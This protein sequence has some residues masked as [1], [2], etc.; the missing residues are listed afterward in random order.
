LI[1]LTLAKA[2]EIGLK[3]QPSLKTME[4]QRNVMAY[5]VDISRTRFFPSFSANSFLTKANSPTIF[6]SVSPSTPSY[7]LMVPGESFWN[8]NVSIM[9]PLFTGGRNVGILKKS[10]LEKE[11]TDYDYQAARL[12]LILQIKTTYRMALYFRELRQTYEELV[13]ESETRAKI[14]RISY[15]AGKVAYINVLRNETRL[16]Q[17]RQTLTN[18]EKDYQ[19]TLAQLR[20]RMGVAPNSVI[21]LAKEPLAPEKV[22]LTREQALDR[23]FK[24]RPDILALSRRL[25]AANAD[26]AVSRSDL[27]PQVAFSATQDFFKGENDSID[28][29]YSVGLLVSFP[30]FRSGETFYKI[31][32]SKENLKQ[33]EYNYQSKILETQAEVDSAWFALHAAAENIETARTGVKQAAEDF[34]I[35]K[36]AYEA[37]KRIQVEYLD[38]QVALFQARTDYAKAI[39]DYNI[40]V[41]QLNRI[42]GKE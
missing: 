24:N 41:D 39:L 8:Q 37:G 7:S 33:A 27:Y 16:A 17:S 14:D 2:I 9:V 5:E 23:A 6:D 13:K 34:R 40:S 15:E 30:F 28:S 25:N 31:G 18:T 35:I 1:S 42:I 12:D 38:A 10:K 11:A 20:A 22:S 26:L 19:T 4:V 29:G 3:N 36:L 32:Q 21:D